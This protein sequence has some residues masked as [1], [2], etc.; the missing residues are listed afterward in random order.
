MKTILVDAWNTLVKNKK[1]DNK[2]L[3]ILDQYSHKKI[4]LTNANEIEQIELGIVKMPYEV[5]TLSHNPEKT[6]ELYFEI[7]C[8]KMKLKKEDLLYIEHN[9]GALKSAR[10]FGIKSI[11]FCSNYRE[12]N[13]FL[14]KNS[15]D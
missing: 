5:F 14:K 3:D 11:L 12:I 13:D 6:N 7:L 1:I 10:L 4:I 2:L 8:K 9:E 15:N